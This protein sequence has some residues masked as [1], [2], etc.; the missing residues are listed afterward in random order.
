MSELRHPP[1]NII[2]YKSVWFSSVQT[3]YA[4]CLESSSAPKH[5]P[6]HSILG[7]LTQPKKSTLE[8][9][10]RPQLFQAPAS[11]PVLEQA[12]KPFVLG[13]TMACRWSMS[14]R[15]K[16]FVA[17]MDEYRAL[18]KELL[19]LPSRF[20]VLYLQGDFD[21]GFLTAAMNL[22][23]KAAKLPMPTQAHGLR[24][25]SRRPSM[26]HRQRCH[27]LGKHLPTTFLKWGLLTK[28]TLSCTSPR[29]TLIL[30]PSMRPC[31]ATFRWS[32]T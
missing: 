1:P 26:Q 10:D 18:T 5:G 7:T 16:A 23:P 8:H 14:H 25:P 11:F 20:E 30:G 27:Q 2:S 21:L 17:V 24:R 29:T 12:S 22:L 9:A 15:N 19:G 13:T 31:R 28:T 6:P 4:P 32:Q 3:Y